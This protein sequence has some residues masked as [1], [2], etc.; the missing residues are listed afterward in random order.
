MSDLQLYVTSSS[1]KVRDTGI[2][3]ERG[4]TDTPDTGPKSDAEFWFLVPSGASCIL[5]E[6]KS[7]AE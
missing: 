4:L 7:A 5:I 3:I 2:T 6:K 1:E